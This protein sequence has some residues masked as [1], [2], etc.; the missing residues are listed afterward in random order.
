MRSLIPTLGACLSVAFS[1]L[2]KPM[3]PGESE[4]RYDL[5]VQLAPETR[6]FDLSGTLRFKTPDTDLATLDFRLDKR[7]KLLKVEVVEPVLRAGL[8]NISQRPSG[9]FTV[10]LPKAFP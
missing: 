3:Y 4:P 8:V 7:V 6:R 9:G 10:V 5:S 1:V 2:G